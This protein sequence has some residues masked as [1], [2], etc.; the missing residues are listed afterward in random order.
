MNLDTLQPVDFFEMVESV[1]VCVAPQEAV[2]DRATVQ[3]LNLL[4]KRHDAYEIHLSPVKGVYQKSILGLDW[5]AVRSD[6][7]Q[8][9]SGMVFY[10]SR[11]VSRG[12][13]HYSKLILE[14]IGSEDLE[15]LSV[16]PNDDMIP[17]EAVWSLAHAQRMQLVIA[18]YNQK[19]RDSS[20]P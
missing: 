5:I 12:K 19:P 4:R 16:G 9:V 14:P 11:G 10:H 1:R 20:A 2:P 8:P 15:D 13:S 7:D 6:D 17:V 18:F 3:S